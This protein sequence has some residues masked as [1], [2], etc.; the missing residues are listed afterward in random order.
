MYKITQYNDISLDGF[1]ATLDDDTSW[2]PKS[3]MIQFEK[4]LSKNDVVIMGRRTY[5]FAVKEKVFPY[6]CKINAIVTHNLTLIKKNGNSN[7]LFY[8]LTP[9]KI[10]DSLSEQGYKNIFLMGGGKLNTSFLK[11]GLI[12]KLI[13][14][15]HPIALGKGIS[16][17]EGLNNH[18]MFKK[19]ST[20]SL[21]G[22]SYVVEY[23]VIGNLQKNP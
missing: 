18:F 5:E 13:L 9:Q 7:I 20:K 11:A 15:I 12:D 22:G 14:T 1:I 3:G 16:L 19:L 10:I 23:K 6:P 17:Y 2:I 8:N 21:Q 4:V